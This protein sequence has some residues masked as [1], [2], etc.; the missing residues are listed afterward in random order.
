MPNFSLQGYVEDRFLKMY[1][2]LVH[3]TQK[4]Y[5]IRM[6]EY[7]SSLGPAGNKMN[8][9][10]LVNFSFLDYVEVGFLKRLPSHTEALI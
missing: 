9:Y 7:S 3:R 10:I 1:L 5:I 8:Q 2:I 4:P 6:S